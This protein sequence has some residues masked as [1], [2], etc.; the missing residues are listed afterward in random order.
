[1]EPGHGDQARQAASLTQQLLAF[2]R[3]QMRE[4]VKLDLNALLLRTEEQ[5]LHLLGDEIDLSLQLSDED[6]RVFGDAGQ[7]EQII[8]NLAVNARDAMPEGGRL[9]VSTE[10]ARVDQPCYPGGR[11]GVGDYVVLTVQDTGHGMDEEV[12]AHVFEPFFTTKPAGVGRGL[13]LSSVYGIVRQCGGHIGIASVPGTGTTFII[14]LP[15]AR[16]NG[17][18]RRA[19]SP[20]AMRRSTYSGP[21]RPVEMPAMQAAA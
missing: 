14:Y 16:G 9:I 15:L 5:V 18:E 11:V 4:P 12:R 3:Q 2:R 10:R 8:M 7:L 17:A 21:P 6:C 19:P 13:G 1:M 20:S